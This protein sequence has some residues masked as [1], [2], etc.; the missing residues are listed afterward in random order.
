MDYKKC[1]LK[2]KELINHLK[3]D[4]SGQDYFWMNEK[5]K[6]EAELT[7]LEGEEDDYGDCTFCGRA[8]SGKC[9]CS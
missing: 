8:H 7:A 1:Y 5:E 9:K 2:Q 3:C 4:I 6:L